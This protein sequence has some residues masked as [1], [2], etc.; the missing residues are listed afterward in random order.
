MM[1][2]RSISGGLKFLNSRFLLAGINLYGAFAVGIHLQLAAF[3]QWH[4]FQLGALW[5]WQNYQRFCLVSLVHSLANVEAIVICDVV[6]LPQFLILQKVRLY[7]F[8]QLFNAFVQSLLF[9]CEF[10]VFSFKLVDVLLDFWWL[11][12]T[13]PLYCVLLKFLHIIYPLQH[14]CDV[15]NSSLLHF[16]LV[17]RLVKVNRVVLPLLDQFDELFGKYR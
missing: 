7:L 16:Q 12:T 1:N 17:D 13:D 9:L 4:C 8:V 2:C 15:V 14:I 3:F 5:R 11:V 10:V 6:V